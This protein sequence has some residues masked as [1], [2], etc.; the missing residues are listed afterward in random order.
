MLIASILIA[1]LASSGNAIAAK[2][3][4][5][6]ITITGIVV[7][8]KGESIIGASIKSSAG[9]GVVTDVKGNFSLNTDSDATLTVSYLGYV[10]Q[11]VKIDG[12]TTITITMAPS[13]NQL[14]DVVVIGYGSQKRKDVTGAITTIKLED[15]PKS[16]MPFINPLEAIQGSAGIN[17]GPSTSAGASPNIVVRGQNS[18]NANSSPLIVLDGVIFNGNISQ[19]NMSDI[20]TFD[21]LKDA[22]SAAIYGSRSANGV[23]II[24]TKRGKTEKPTINFN[25][26]YG[27]QNWTR[28]PKMRT[29][30]DFLQWRKDNLSI[31]GIDISDITKVL[32]PLELKAYNE[33]HTL[34][35]MDEVTQYAPIQNYELSV[36]GRTDKLNYYFSTGYLDQKGV[37][38]NDRFKR[39]SFTVKLENNITDWLSY[40]ANGYYSGMD[41]TGY[42]PG[43]YM[44]TYMSPYSYKYVDGTN[45]QLL[46]RYPAG[47]TSL[48]NPLWGNNT[49]ITAGEYDENLERSSNIRGTGF[50]NAK[51]PFVNGLNF[52]FDVTG[53]ESTT[54]LG[55]FHHEGGEVNTL[56]P[57]QIAN[58]AQFLPRAN[59]YRTNSIVSSWLTNSL[60]SYTRFF[61]KHTIDALVGY[62]RDDYQME[63]TRLGG[64][65]FG[66][67][68][69]TSLGFRGLHLATVKTGQTDYTRYS[70]IGYIGRLNYNYAQKYYATFNI[71]K[72]GYSAFADGHKF[73]WFPGG[74][75]AWAL[76]EEDFMESMIFVNYLKLRV[77]YGGTGNQG[78]APL[79]TQALVGQGFTVFG[80]TSTAFLNPSSLAN[81]FLTWEKTTALNFGLDFNLFD[82]RVSGNIDVYNSTTTDQL[83][84]RSLPI[85][86]GY[87][88]VNSNYGEVQNKGIEITVNTINIKSDTGFG[89]ESGFSFWMNRNKLV[90]L[91]FA[92]ANG[93]GKED[94][95]IDNRLFI[96]KSLGA[97]YD[98][99]VDG[100]VK[101]SDSEYINKYRTN[102]GGQIFFPGDLKIRDINNDGVIDAKDRSIIGYGKENFNFNISNTFSYKN[103]N[104]FFSINSIVGGGKNNF[105]SS[106]NLRG[107]NPGQTLPTQANWLND[108]Y[109]MPD[110]ESNRNPRPNYSNPYG[111]GFYQSRTFVRLQSASLNYTFSTKIT[112]KLKIDNLK[113]FVSGTNLIT[114]TGWTGLDPA[115]GAQI[116]GNGGSSNI[117]VNA[118]LPLMRTVSLGFN[119]GF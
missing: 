71:R 8:E 18:I 20:A 27:E 68:G 88:S 72:D 64:N 95:D 92:D 96:G 105:F 6:P 17:I 109:W 13:E 108:E 85:F 35:W 63:S 61:K 25:T 50:L 93:D 67:A 30:E 80:N 45:N 97:N 113:A 7:D 43:L 101:S 99:T 74:S 38:Y 39:P 115:N 76:S 24:T 112:Q 16:S 40:G 60:L 102:T 98:Y 117:N 15:S 55:H 57:A 10:T 52:R 90:H 69:T 59:G 12:R 111:Y 56:V 119:L 79:A 32:N 46:Q 4:F 48:Y 87:N 91:T 26:Y 5:A 70:N 42:S 2:N 65:D 77:S 19:I 28:V 84:I 89:W 106:T 51:I 86:T 21:I 62:T 110:R 75:V 83:L 114:L 31:R 49:E 73:G 107:K 66:N 118:S 22:S 82:N 14:D 81:T 116:G 100:I 34:D 11:Q 3:L 103:F 1:L 94:D 47:S 53:S 33:G 41:Y 36:S 78:I 29:G 23:V 9:G 104:L 58:P 37:M 54:E 44:A